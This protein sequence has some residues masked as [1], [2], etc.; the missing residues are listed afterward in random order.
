MSSFDEL[1]AALGARKQEIYGTNPWLLGGNALVKQ[2]F[3][4]PQSS[5]TS[6]LG[7]ALLTG[8]GGGFARG[9]GKQ[10]AEQ[11]YL[12]EASALG[13]VL[14][15]QGPQRME[16]IDANPA[17][18]PYKPLIV[19]GQKREEEEQARLLAKIQQQK[20]MIDYQQ[21]AKAKY[22][23]AKPMRG[24]QAT[25]GSQPDILAATGTPEAG[26]LGVVGML[27]DG[28][29]FGVEN[30]NDMQARLVREKLAM[31]IPGGAAES[32]ASR[33]VEALRKRGQKQI[34]E[35]LAKDAEKMRE[36]EDLVRKGREGIDK[37]G[38]TGFPGTSTYEKLAA[39]L[40]WA[41]EAQEQSSG[42]A[43][44]M[45]TRQI[46]G[47]INRIVGSGAMNAEES[48]ALFSSAMSPDQNKSQNEAL[49]RGY[50]N[51]LAVMKEHAAFMNYFI[52]KTGGNPESAQAM[53]E[54]YK[55]ANPIVVQDPETGN[56]VVNETRE[57]WKKFNFKKAYQDSISGATP[58][59]GLTVGGI[60]E[61]T[62]KK[63]KSIKRRS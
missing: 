42:D 9:Y 49:L 37:A 60:L 25:V 6:N 2:D 41:K 19:L 40:P 39:N 22:A 23:I 43:K 52:D 13:S 33:Q 15:M 24:S 45:E 10:Q 11:E 20:D 12:D 44:L 36:I 17:L 30:L 58:A 34:V 8:L 29:D 18:Q 48:K 3:Y 62:N 53:W 1:V 21:M 32:S 59:G 50:E 27:D 4:N 54:L 55:E 16:A 28:P 47:A 7:A 61:G 63:I 51:G 35:G 38:E 31:G 5:N 14:D 26:A 57:P 46:T 56:F